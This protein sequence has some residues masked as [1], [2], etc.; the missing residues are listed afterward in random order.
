MSLKSWVYIVRLTSRVTSFNHRT[1]L[2]LPVRALTDIPLELTLVCCLVFLVISVLV[3][4]GR[5]STGR[6]FGSKLKSM[7]VISTNLQDLQVLAET[8][9]LRWSRTLIMRTCSLPQ[10]STVQHSERPEP[11]AGGNI[12]LKRKRRM[13]VT[14]GTRA[15]TC[16]ITCFFFSTNFQFY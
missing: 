7:S 8:S 14:A 10:R 13:P 15:Q 9:T 5:A 1:I 3:Q 6:F 12:H 11:M 4:S 16:G 2:T